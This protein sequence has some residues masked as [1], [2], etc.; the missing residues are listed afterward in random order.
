MQAVDFE[1]I[2]LGTKAMQIGGI[3]M[4]QT[5]EDEIIFEAPGIWGSNARIR[6]GVRLK[7]GPLVFY[8][9][10]ELADLQV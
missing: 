7:F 3:K 5:S 6:V 9:P 2:D 1:A 4:Y 8:L 10:V